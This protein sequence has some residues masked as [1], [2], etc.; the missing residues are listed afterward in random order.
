MPIPNTLVTGSYTVV[1]TYSG[2]S[3]Y[4]AT[5]TPTI[6]QVQINQVTPNITWSP[7][8]AI[9]YGATLSRILNASALNGG[10]P[11]TGGFTYTATPSGGSASTLTSSTVLAAGS[12]TLAATFTPA[13]PTTYTSSSANVSLTVNKATPT[14]SLVSSLNP[15]LKTNAVAFTATVTS[16]EGAPRGSVSFNDGQTLLGSGTLAAGVAT[17][18]TSSLTVGPHSI[19]AAYGGDANFTSVTSAVVSQPVEDFTLIISTSSGGSTS[20]TAP[21]GSSASYVFQ[22]SPSS[23]S[24]FPSIVTFTVSGLPAGATATLTPQ[25]LPAGSGTVTITLVIHL[26]N[27]ILALHPAHS[28]GRGLALAM[29]G[30]MFLL[31]FGGK[32]RQPA[33]RAG[34]FASLLLLILAATCATL[35]LTACGG[36][37]SG[38]F[39]Q[40]VQNYTVTVTATSGSLSHLTTVNLTVK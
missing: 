2:D 14:V 34:R 1:I 32:M 8:S 27:Q 11:V 37:G 20:A 30:G 3:N 28:L 9:T 23:G 29:V 24:T 15:V 5:S 21:P 40:Q 18:S 10:S 22:V 31:P 36:R 25:T 12:Y 19:T 6:I 33:G 39:G 7:A 16:T 13:D 35:G 17:Y 26:A 4:L 38:Y